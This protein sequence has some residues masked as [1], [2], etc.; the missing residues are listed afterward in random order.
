MR[1][2]S[3][4]GSYLTLIDFAYRSTLGLRVIKKKVSKRTWTITSAVARIWFSMPA[5]REKDIRPPLFSI[6]Y[7]YLLLLLLYSRYR[8]LKV[9]EPYTHIQPTVWGRVARRA[10]GAC[11]LSL[12]LLSLSPL[13]TVLPI[14]GRF[15]REPGRSRPRSRESGS[16]CRHTALLSKGNKSYYT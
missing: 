11:S 16:A 5:Y 13:Y 10:G 15:P 6:A 7:P 1:S 12:S 4:A 2:G 8:S 3:E 9:L 14:G